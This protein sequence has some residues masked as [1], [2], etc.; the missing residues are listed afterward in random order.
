MSIY[1]D[2]NATGLLDPEVIQTLK[3]ALDLPLA[4]PS[5]PHSYGQAAKGRLSEA[6]R[7]IALFLKVGQSQVF[8]KSSHHLFKY[9]ASVRL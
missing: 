3:E 9:R 5:S 6:R 1:L 4:N 2:S 7:K 8:F